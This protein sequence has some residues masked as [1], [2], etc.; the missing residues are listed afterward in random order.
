M[1]HQN[2]IHSLIDGTIHALKLVVPSQVNLQEYTITNE[3]YKQKEIGVLIGLIGDLKGRIIIDSASAT[4]S[5]LGLKMFG[6][7][8]EGEMLESFTG[9]FGNMLVGN[10][11]TYAGLQSINVDITTPTVMV[12]ETKLSGFESAYHLPVSIEDI[13]DLTILITIDE[14]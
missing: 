1:N 10:L 11:C 12:G 7:P 6:M 9:E 13:G 2:Y 4:F 14:A 8:L 3:P 5:G